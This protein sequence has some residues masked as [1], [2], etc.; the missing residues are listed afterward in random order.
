MFLEFNLKL[1]ILFQ[2]TEWQSCLSAT[3]FYLA[4]PILW[5]NVD[6]GIQGDSRTA[7]NGLRWVSDKGFTNSGVAKS[8]PGEQ[9][10]VEMT[11][12]EYF[13]NLAGSNCYKIPAIPPNPIL[14][15]R[16]LKRAGFY[17][18]NYDD[19]NHPPTFNLTIDGKE[20]STVNNSVIDEPMYIEAMYVIHELG[21]INFV[22]EPNLTPRCAIY[23]FYRGRPN[24][25]LRGL[26][27]PTNGH[28]CHIPSNK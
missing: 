12:L 9:P 21:F 26:Y 11:T 19:L 20:W 25:K 7:L 10:S 6:C 24:D 28:R 23:F 3:P 1:C 4:L 27:V 14:T 2:K 15:P 22:P 13:P 8:L 16:Y 18:S 17:Y 5:L